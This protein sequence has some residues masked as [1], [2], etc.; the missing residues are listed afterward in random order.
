MDFTVPKDHKVKI[1]EKLSK[2]LDLS[3]ELEKLWNMRMTVIPI[4]VEELGT[5]V[6]DL[7]KRL[8]T[9]DH[10]KNRDHNVQRTVQIIYNTYISV[11]GIYRLAIS[12]TH[13]LEL[14]KMKLTIIMIIIIII[15][16]IIK[17]VDLAK[18]LKKL[19][20]IRVMMIL[21]VIGA[22]GTV[23]GGLGN[24]RTSGDHQDYSIVEIGQ[25]TEKSP[26]D[27][28]RLAVIQTPV[29]NHQQTLM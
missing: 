23:T 6:K 28:R 1:K 17:F 15:I 13:K 11:M 20:N 19:W 22:L 12:Q 25:N 27:L 18:E 16:I 8:V 5:V 3:R 24:K 10:E 4:V 14:A 26:E 9:V 21:I 2:Y 29:K 7:E